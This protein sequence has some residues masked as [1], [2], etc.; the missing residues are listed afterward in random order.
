MI[1]I[2]RR[3]GVSLMEVLVTISVIGMLLSLLLPAVHASREAARQT[4]CK[5]N[6]RQ[7]ALAALIHENAIGQFP[8]GGWG[9]TWYGDPDRGTGSSQ[10][11]GWTYNLLRYVE[12]ADLARLGAGKTAAEKRSAIG[13]V[14]S[15]PLSVFYC[16]SR[17][18]VGLY[19][20]DPD[21]PPV[22][23][24]R[25]PL[26]DKCDYAANS[27]DLLVNANPGPPCLAAG[28]DPMYPWP[29]FSK[30]SGIVHMRSTTRLADVRDG[31][32]FTYLFGEKHM[33]TI[34][35]E[36]GDDQGAFVGYDWDTTRWTTLGWTPLP[37][38]GPV[39]ADRFGG[40]HPWACL[41]AFCDGAVHAISFDVDAEVHRRFGNR[42]DGGINTDN[43]FR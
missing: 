23:A 18:A 17:R 22:N 33:G 43:E 11:G 42:H 5:N 21:W 31:T 20:L 2:R 8:S 14:N 40:P 37:D 25:T 7:L 41:F 35:Y 13:A 15:T 12:R 26:I 19:P 10:P 4:V 32:M 1:T 30:S 16:P 28:D 9:W 6:L 3:C 34:G 27:G 38:G 36:S 24:T 39:A 29:D